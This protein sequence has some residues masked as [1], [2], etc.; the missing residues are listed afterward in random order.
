MLLTC[1]TYKTKQNR[2]KTLKLI[3]TENR[4]VVARGREEGGGWGKWM[5]W[6]TRYKLAVIR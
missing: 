2:T 3:E 6:V 4:L 1:G 5:K